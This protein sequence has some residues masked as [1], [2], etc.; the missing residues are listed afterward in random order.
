MA[1]EEK[2]KR[3]GWQLF[4]FFGIGCDIFIF[5]IVGY[6]IGI[7]YEMEI[8]GMAVGAIIGTIFMLVHYWLTLKNIEKKFEEQEEEEV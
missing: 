5:A 1:H 3:L 6:F 4:K 2:E 7:N 8:L